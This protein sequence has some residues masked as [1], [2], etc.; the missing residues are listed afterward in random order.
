MKTRSRLHSESKFRLVMEK[1]H[2][3]SLLVGLYILVIQISPTQEHKHSKGIRQPST[4]TQLFI[5]ESVIPDPAIFFCFLLEAHA[6]VS[7]RVDL[8][9]MSTT[10]HIKELAVG[11]GERLSH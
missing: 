2:V 11:G 3:H 5:A 10:K 9:S 1:R 4:N 6:L 7:K 8:G